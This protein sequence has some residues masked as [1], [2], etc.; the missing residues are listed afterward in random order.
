MTSRRTQCPL[1]FA[2]QYTQ[3]PHLWDSWL[4]LN[5]PKVSLVEG[6]LDGVSAPESS[7]IDQLTR[8][9]SALF[10]ISFTEIQEER[11]SNFLFTTP[12]SSSHYAP[13]T[14]SCV[15]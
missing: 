7:L 10:S 6:C 3:P 4:K 8:N 13:V 9:G 11:Q 15:V 12:N 14:V 2:V 5:H 1:A